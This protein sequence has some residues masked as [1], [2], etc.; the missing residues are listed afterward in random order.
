MCD[1]CHLAGRTTDAE[2]NEPLEGTPAEA[3]ERATEALVAL[4]K[5]DERGEFAMTTLKVGSLARQAIRSPEVNDQVL[6]IA[7]TAGLAVVS[8]MSTGEE[9]KDDDPPFPQPISTI[10]YMQETFPK[11]RTIKW[12]YSVFVEVAARFGVI[13]GWMFLLGVYVVREGRLQEFA[14][15]LSE[16]ELRALEGELRDTEGADCENCDHP[17]GA[18]EEGGMIVE[19][20]VRLIGDDDVSAYNDG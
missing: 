15:V 14:R 7:L 10:E 11:E 5:D 17:C 6:A 13:V 18:Q 9:V 16:E 2:S 1:A 3:F 20:F 8:Q 19:E 12:V 4:N